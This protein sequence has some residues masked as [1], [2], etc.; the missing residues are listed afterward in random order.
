MASAGDGMHGDGIQFPNE[1][2]ALRRNLV[3]GAQVGVVHK[4]VSKMSDNMVIPKCLPSE[5]FFI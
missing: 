4:Q 5:R 2:V 1:K 3:L